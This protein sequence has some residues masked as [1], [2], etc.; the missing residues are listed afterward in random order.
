MKNGNSGYMT[1]DWE[2]SKIS[3]WYGLMDQSDNNKA[4]PPFK[5][6]VRLPY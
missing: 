2:P 3:F 5:P 6:A 1:N 4:I